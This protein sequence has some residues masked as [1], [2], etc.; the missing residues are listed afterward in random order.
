[1]HPDPSWDVPKPFQSLLKTQNKTWLPLKYP[2][3]L[4]HQ[5]KYLSTLSPPKKK[6]WRQICSLVFHMMF[7]SFSIVTP[8]Q[9][10]HRRGFVVPRSWLA[11]SPDLRC[12]SWVNHYDWRCRCQASKMPG[13][14]FGRLAWGMKQGLSLGGRWTWLVFGC[15]FEKNCQDFCLRCQKIE[16]I[17]MIRLLE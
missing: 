9:L 13:W 6:S 15:L 10:Q 14:N 1:M 12:W 8:F 5:I 16:C 2:F 4:K 3:H 7:P 11:S 17:S